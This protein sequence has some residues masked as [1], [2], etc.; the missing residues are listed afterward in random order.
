MKYI[1]AS[2]VLPKELLSM[3]QIYYQGGYLY[4]PT[5]HYCAVKQQT[6]YKIELEKRNHHIFLK[7]LEGRTNGQLGN[8][9]HLS[10]SSVRRIISKE[11]ARY[12]KMKESIEHILSLWEIEMGQISQIYPSAWEINHS[13]VKKVYDDKRQLERNIKISETLLDCN[14]PVA[15]TVL[16]K[17][18]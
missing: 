16:T 8:I 6:D 18:G 9:Y 5:D 14:I 4:I 13:Y 15:K 1:N 11:K 12:R 17:A 10:V 7:H 3:I 2:D